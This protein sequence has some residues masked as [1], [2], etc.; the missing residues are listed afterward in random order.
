M[1][2]TRQRSGYRRNSKYLNRLPRNSL[3]QIN[4]GQ[5]VPLEDLSK[6]D[7]EKLLR[8]QGVPFQTLVPMLRLPANN[9]PEGNIL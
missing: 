7:K 8:E 2:D 4:S 9:Q 5:P 3:Q 1:R 6:A